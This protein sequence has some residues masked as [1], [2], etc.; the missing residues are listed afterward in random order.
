[1]VSEPTT[2]DLEAEDMK[3]MK[4]HGTCTFPTI[5]A[6]DYMAR[7]VVIP[8]YFSAAGRGESHSDR[9]AG[10]RHRGRAYKAGVK[11]ALGTDAGVYPH[12]QNAHEFELM[13]QAGMSPLFTI[14][15]ATVHAAQLLKRDKDSAASL[16]ASWLILVA[17]R[18]NPSMTSAC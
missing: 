4:E 2:R 10:S 3:L 18:G 8:G 16:R 13:V 12:G 17:V 6:G 5:I 15:T 9:A 7:K 14:Q 11:I 1:M